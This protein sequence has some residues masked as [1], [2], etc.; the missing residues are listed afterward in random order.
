MSIVKPNEPKMLSGS[1]QKARSRLFL[2]KH[3]THG[4]SRLP[5]GTAGA[6]SFVSLQLNMV[7]PTSRLRMKAGASARNANRISPKT[8]PTSIAVS[9]PP[10]E[11]FV[12]VT[13][14]GHNDHDLIAEPVRFF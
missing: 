14:I 3:G 2:C 8:R 7:N 5:V 6:T 12:W 11:K 1:N 13:V 9:P 10:I 4:H